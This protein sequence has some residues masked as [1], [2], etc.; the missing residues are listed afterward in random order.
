MVTHADSLPSRSAIDVHDFGAP[1]F[2]TWSCNLYDLEPET[3]KLQTHFLSNR[4]LPITGPFGATEVLRKP[5]R[6]ELLTFFSSLGTNPYDISQKCEGGA[7]DPRYPV[8]RYI[9]EYLD[10]LGIPATLTQRSVAAFLSMTDE[11]HTSDS[12]VAELHERAGSSARS[13]WN[14]CLNLQPAL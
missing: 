14:I 5:L 9:R 13:C 3:F 8:T 6:V 1:I 7:E 11:S 12:Y 10:N 2:M 4:N